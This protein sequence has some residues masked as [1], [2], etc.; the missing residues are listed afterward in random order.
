M[1]IAAATA[2]VADLHR[3]K[4]FVVSKSSPA[5]RFGPSAET[6]AA[7]KTRLPLRLP[8]PEE[9][10]PHQAVR[11]LDLGTDRSPRPEDDLGRR[12]VV[13]EFS[14]GLERSATVG[15]APAGRLSTG[16]RLAAYQPTDAQLEAYAQQALY[17]TGVLSFSRLWVEVRRQR[18]VVLGALPDEFELSL[19][20]QTVRRVNGIVSVEHQVRLVGAPGNKHVVSSAQS[21]GKRRRVSG[22]LAWAATPV[23]SLWVGWRVLMLKAL[24]ERFDFEE[25]A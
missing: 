15:D 12:R 4:G 20:L 3:R 18:A 25:D 5:H 1:S 7:S 23:L 9:T 24:S 6:L 11:R 8:L 22:W 17:R 14:G 19:A 2:T 21:D 16:R 13:A 10:G